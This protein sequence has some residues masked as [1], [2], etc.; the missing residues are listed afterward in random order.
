MII[1]NNHVVLR[2]FSFNQVFQ[3]YLLYCCYVPT[4]LWFGPG[5]V[6]WTEVQLAAAVV[7]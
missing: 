4:A 3:F 1:D 7:M 5:L 6:K 2:Y